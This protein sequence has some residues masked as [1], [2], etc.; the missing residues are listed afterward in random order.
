[1][2]ERT[3]DFVVCS[4]VA[5]HCHRPAEEFPR[6]DGLLKPGGRLGIMTGI[7]TDDDRFADWHYRRDPTH[8]VFYRPETFA[9]IARRHH[10]HLEFPAEN[11]VLFRKDARS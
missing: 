11:V 8:V 4:E 2:L 9:H 10:W 7:L 5:E 1:M 3:Y 6:L